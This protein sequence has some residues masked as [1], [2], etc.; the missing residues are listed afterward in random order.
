MDVGQTDTL[1]QRLPADILFYTFSLIAH[2]DRPSL[3]SCSKHGP[4]P[5]DT[6]YCCSGFAYC[7]F[8]T[9]DP[10][11]DLDFSSPQTQRTRLRE[12]EGCVY[13]LGWVRLGHVCRSWRSV[14]LDMRSL[15]AKDICTLNNVAMAVFLH[16]AQRRPLNLDF[17]SATGEHMRRM[18]S[19]AERAA[20]LQANVPKARTIR[21]T[22]FR[23]DITYLDG[24]ALPLLE[25]LDLSLTSPRPRE[26]AINAPNLRRVKL[27]GPIVLHATP[28]L[29][30]ATINN[31]T[32][33]TEAP[34]LQDLELKGLAPRVQELPR[35]LAKLPCLEDLSIIMTGPP[36]RGTVD[37]QYIEY[38]HGHDVLGLRSRNIT[39]SLPA[40]TQLR[41]F[42][43]GATHRSVCGLLAHLTTSSECNLQ[44]LDVHCTHSEFAKSSLAIIAFRTAA[45]NISANS[46]YLHFR[47]SG[48]GAVAVVSASRIEDRY[49]SK[50]RSS[51][52]F[53]M[54]IPAAVIDNEWS[55]RATF[56]RLLP[57]ELFTHL[58]LEC[59]PILGPDNPAQSVLR[60][61][62]SQL[63]CVHTLWVSDNERYPPPTEADDGSYPL[64]GALPSLSIPSLKT[65]HISYTRGIF[66]DWWKR[67]AIAVAARQR[68]ATRTALEMFH[69]Q[70]GVDLH[71]PDVF[72]LNAPIE[73]FNV[74]R[75]SVWAKEK[76]SDV[77]RSLF[78]QIVEEIEVEELEATD[79]KPVWP[80]SL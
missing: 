33:L 11:S 3:C 12:P 78:A 6:E 69:E 39:L 50:H 16:R 74:D 34:S 58:F 17:D 61:A 57:S 4:S 36:H 72:V 53:E 48:G 75:S 56:R 76:V 35:L 64:A 59:L 19:R 71:A 42:G 13:S 5:H 43:Y 24:Q 65:L 40:L 46:V 32:S 60:A 30:R 29:L 73:A 8:C 38:D 9:H 80:P 18:G 14:L 26:L 10:T 55:I 22:R 63:R 70:P 20:L 52:T 27:S 47:N 77:A 67:L 7:E 51:T 79:L 41:V 2:Y 54:Y 37:T 62:L 28:K 45:Y 66:R 15:W 21:L 25:V 1:S 68:G 23:G 49:D 44:R 31:L